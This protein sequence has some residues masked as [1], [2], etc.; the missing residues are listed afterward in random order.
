MI[1]FDNST[2]RFNFVLYGT[3]RTGSNLLKGLIN[4]LD[5]V[6]CYPEILGPPH[7]KKQHGLETKEDFKKKS[8]KIS[9]ILL[10]YRSIEKI[11]TITYMLE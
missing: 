11:M 9:M 10:S 2:Q 8:L 4:H 5:E 1:D 6:I 3:G 7:L